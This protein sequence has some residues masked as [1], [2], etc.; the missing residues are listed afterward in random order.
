[1]RLVSRTAGSKARKIVKS[2]FLPTALYGALVTGVSDAFLLNLRRSA[3][4]AATPRAAGRSLDVALGLSAL[5]VTGKA[6]APPLVRW[7]AE[8]WNATGGFDRTL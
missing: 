3:S 7:A 6:T 4:A 5:E 2:G 8:V 1:M